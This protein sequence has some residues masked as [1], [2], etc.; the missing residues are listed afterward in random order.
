MQESLMA[1][2]T[3]TPDSSEHSAVGV[4][5]DSSH[6]SRRD[7]SRELARDGL[8]DAREW[9]Q[10]SLT[11]AQGLADWLEQ[12]Q[13]M[14]TDAA[15]GWA[16][17]LAKA[18]REVR[19]AEDLAALMAVPA[20]LVNYQMDL[21]LRHFNDQS[22]RLIETELEWADQTRE[23]AL[24]LGQTWMADRTDGNGASMPA[25]DVLKR[26]QEA[27]SDMWQRWIDGMNTGQKQPA[28]AAAR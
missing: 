23:R 9:W 13:R 12:T 28:A 8:T 11:V 27:W 5:S 17:S 1:R 22:K 20:N 6:D 10:Q 19:Q 18:E 15:R 25:T 21:A 24:A 7:I 26:T 3:K 2:Q 14:N 16:E 4:G